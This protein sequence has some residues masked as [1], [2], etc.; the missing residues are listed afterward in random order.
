MLLLDE[1]N[2]RGRNAMLLMTQSRDRHCC[3]PPRGI[4]SVHADVNRKDR[5]PNTVAY[6]LR[7]PFGRTDISVRQALETGLPDMTVFLGFRPRN[8]GPSAPCR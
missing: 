8:T 3:A 6:Q 1:R 4:P 7:S 5:L 2:I